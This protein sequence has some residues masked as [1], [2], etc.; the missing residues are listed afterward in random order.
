MNSRKESFISIFPDN[1][2]SRR[3]TWPTSIPHQWQKHKFRGCPDTEPFKS[4]LTPKKSKRRSTTMPCFFILVY[5]LG[6]AAIFVFLFYD[7]TGPVDQDESR[8]ISDKY[9]EVQNNTFRVRHRKLEHVIMKKLCKKYPQN[10]EKLN[11]WSI[12][13]LNFKKVVT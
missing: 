4:G 11:K 1:F 2:S 9:S 10:C 3:H 8:R 7:F 5:V 6:F 13:I 12:I